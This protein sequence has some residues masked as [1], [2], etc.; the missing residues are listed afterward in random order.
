[1]PNDDFGNA[2]I[3]DERMALMRGV[4]VSLATA[5]LA[6]AARRHLLSLAGRYCD[7]SSLGL[8]SSLSPRSPEIALEA[9][10]TATHVVV[11][12][13]ATSNTNDDIGLTRMRRHTV[14]S[15]LL[16]AIERALN[17]EPIDSFTRPR[18]RQS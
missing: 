1:M 10:D 3:I 17:G 4:K 7:G 11:K 13:I 8:S 16:G 18:A 14:R 2:S 5:S 6:P 12:A 15:F 9:D